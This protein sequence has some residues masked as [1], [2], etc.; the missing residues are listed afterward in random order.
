MNRFPYSE[1]GR[2]SV[3]KGNAEM[4]GF[5]LEMREEG[6]DIKQAGS[7]LGGRG[8]G[9]TGCLGGQRE[10]RGVRRN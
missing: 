10:R 4:P 8:N 6:C 3:K 7:A 2:V 5:E 1:K 9:K